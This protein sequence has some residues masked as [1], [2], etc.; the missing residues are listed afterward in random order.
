LAP[1]LL[2]SPCLCELNFGGVQ[3][4]GQ[5]ARDRLAREHRDFRLLC[6]GKVTGIEHAADC[7]PSRL[8][9][10]RRAI[11]LRSVTGDA[12]FWHVGMLK[13]LP[14]LGR[15]RGRIHLF[16]HG[17]ECW[18][19]LDPVSQHLL[20][21]V[22]LFLT[23][24]SFTWGRFIENNP[25]WANSNHRVVALGLDAPREAS[26][27]PGPVP[28]ALIL[29]RM[30]KGEGYKGHEELIRAWPM[31]RRQIPSA[32][33]WIA[34]GGALE[35]ELKQIAA[36]VGESNHIRFFGVITEERK[37][38]L[39]GEARCL[40]LPSRGEGFGLVYLEAM[41]LGRPCLASTVDAGREV[42]HPPE[43]GLA[44]DPVNLTAISDA[45]VRLLTPGTEW[46]SWSRSAKARYESEFTAKHFEERLLLTL[47]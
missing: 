38:H 11:A 35:P 22:D 14:L 4:S 19:K 15:R 23:N 29:G 12:L 39:I 9:A 16:L 41:R 32:E 5:I 6:Y 34:G 31:V 46:E 24:S 36:Q 10:M 40:A 28:A 20:G 44:V 3:L 27:L 47:R 33:L 37:Q 45:I 21:S 1:F 43:A 18:R 13:L 30:Q 17:I 7:A 2:L 26:P 8:H 25:R 42:V